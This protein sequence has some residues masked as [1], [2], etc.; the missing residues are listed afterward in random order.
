MGTLKSYDYILNPRPNITVTV[1]NAN[2]SCSECLKKKFQLRSWRNVTPSKKVYPPPPRR[3]QSTPVL[4]QGQITAIKEGEL[5]APDVSAVW[6]V[7]RPAAQVTLGT[8]HVR[9][10]ASCLNFIN[11]K[12]LDGAC[13]TSVHKGVK[14][15]FQHRRKHWFS[16]SP[17]S[18]HGCYCC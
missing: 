9:R 10:E 2:Y 8:S 6:E 15:S 3:Q 14:I 17:C 4:I 18:F 11:S 13:E 1:G 5:R 16:F 12:P 7:I